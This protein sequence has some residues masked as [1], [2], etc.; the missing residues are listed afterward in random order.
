MKQTCITKT[1]ATFD[2]D[3][4]K[5]TQAYFD[6]AK[7]RVGT[8]NVNRAGWQSVL[9]ACISIVFD[10][11]IIEYYNAGAGERGYQTLI[12]DALRRAVD[13]AHFVEEMCS[14]IRG[15][16]TSLVGRKKNPA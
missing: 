9:S 8:E 6:R 4:P 16:L 5:L 3:A 13:G 7:F 15:E 10:T 11:S 14:V 1:P 2:D 12:N